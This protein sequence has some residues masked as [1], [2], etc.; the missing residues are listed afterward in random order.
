[1]AERKHRHA[2]IS[3]F[4]KVAKE[5]GVVLESINR[6]TAQWAADD[7]LESYSADDLKSAMAW[8]F[9]VNPN[10]TWNIYTR[11]VGELLKAKKS[12]E[13]DERFRAERRKQAKEW[14][15]G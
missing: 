9:K 10:P 1:M 2:L 7:L 13:D 4:E 12:Q 8:L 15:N 5:N 6:H 14:L 11:N 3:H